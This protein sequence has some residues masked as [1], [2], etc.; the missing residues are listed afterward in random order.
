[1]GSSAV[2]LF[3]TQTP[4]ASVTI[5]GLRLVAVALPESFPLPAASFLALRAF[6]IGAAAVSVG[7]T[8]AAGPPLRLQD[9]VIVTPS[10]RA[11]AI[12]QDFACRNSPSPNFTV[13]PGSLHVLSFASPSVSAVNV[14]L[15]CSGA[16]PPPQPCT[17]H[18]VNTAADLAAALAPPSSGPVSVPDPRAGRSTF[19]EV[20][21]YVLLNRSVALRDAWEVLRAAPDA[22]TTGLSEG[23]KYTNPLIIAGAT[24]G[25]AGWASTD[26]GPATAASGAAPAAAG[27]GAYLCAAQSAGG[28]CYQPPPTTLDLG[29]TSWLMPLTTDS[30]VQ[31]RNLTVLN[32][33]L[34]PASQ[35]PFGLLT[36]PL[37]TFGFK[38]QLVGQRNSRWVLVGRGLALVL[39][40]EE[41]ALWHAD[42]LGVGR[43]PE[44][45]AGCGLCAV[46]NGLMMVEPASY[47]DDG[48]QDLSTGAALGMPLAGGGLYLPKLRS[49]YYGLFVFE[50]ALLMPQRLPPATS[51]E[52][53]ACEA[54]MLRQQQG[55]IGG[56]G[57]AAASVRSWSWPRPRPS[58]LSPL[59]QL[60]G[61][62]ATQP[63]RVENV[64]QTWGVLSPL[65]LTEG[66]GTGNAYVPDPYGG[67]LTVVF[68]GDSKLRVAL[69][70]QRSVFSAFA[71]YQAQTAGADIWLGDPLRPRLLNLMLVPAVSNLWGAN[72]SLTLRQLVLGGLAP[73]GLH[74]SSAAALSAGSAL[75]AAQAAGAGTQA[76]EVTGAPSEGSSAAAPSQPSGRRLQLSR[77]GKAA[78]HCVETWELSHS[79]R[80]RRLG[81]Y[82]N[83]YGNYTFLGPAPGVDPTGGLPAALTNFTSCLWALDMNRAPPSREPPPAAAEEATPGDP[84]NTTG[85]GDAFAL[86]PRAFLDSVVLLVPPGELAVLAAAW[87]ER[88]GTGGGEADSR[89]GYEVVASPGAAADPAL[90]SAA[91]REL[92]AAISASRLAAGA[93]AA[94]LQRLTTRLLGMAGPG[95]AAEGA[96]APAALAFESFEW[97]G[98]AGRNVTLAAELLASWQ[99]ADMPLWRD[100]LWHPD[101]LELPLAVA[102]RQQQRQQPAP[103]PSSAG[104]PAAPARPKAPPL[105][106]VRSPLAP[107]QQGQQQQQQQ[108]QQQE[109][110]VQQEAPTAYKAA[111][112]PSMATAAALA[113]SLA[114]SVCVAVCLGSVWL[115]WRR[116]RRRQGATA[117]VGGVARHD[118]D[119]SD[120]PISK[121]HRAA[122]P[123][124]GSCVER[125]EAAVPGSGAAPGWPRLACMLADILAGGSSGGHSGSGGGS[126]A[127]QGSDVHPVCGRDGQVSR[128][129]VSLELGPLGGP[130][131]S[132]AAAA[133]RKGRASSGTGGTGSEPGGSAFASSGSR[134]PTLANAAAPW[135]LGPD[136]HRGSRPPGSSTLA[137]TLSALYR[138]MAD[139]AHQVAAATTAGEAPAPAPAQPGRCRGSG[140]GGTRGT[141]DGADGYASGADGSGCTEGC[142]GRADAAQP[143]SGHSERP[144]NGGSAVLGLLGGPCVAGRFTTHDGATMQAGSSSS[145]AAGRG[146]A[147][148]SG[149][150]A[151]A[152]AGGSARPPPGEMVLLGELGRGAQGVVLLARWRGLE[153]AVKS[154]TFQADGDPWA[155]HHIWEAALAVT[156]SH[157]NVVATYA[158]QLF[159]VQPADLQPSLAG[160]PRNRH[161]PPHPGSTTAHTEDRATEL[162]GPSPASL[163]A[164]VWRLTLVQE[165]CGAGSLRQCLDSGLLAACRVAGAPPAAVAAAGAAGAAP[166]V[167]AA[168]GVESRPAVLA[169]QSA[170]ASPYRA[171]HM[172]EGSRADNAAAEPGG[173]AAEATARGPGTEQGGSPGAGGAFEEHGSARRVRRCARAEAGTFWSERLPTPQADV[174]TEAEAGV[175]AALDTAQVPAPL[176]CLLVAVQVA[177]G[178]AYLHSRGVLHCDLSSSNV[179][180]R[181]EAAPCSQQ[182]PPQQLQLQRRQLEEQRQRQCLRFLDTDSQPTGGMAEATLSALLAA[183]EQPT[184]TASGSE[185]GIGSLPA[186]GAGGRVSSVPLGGEWRPSG[187]GGGRPGYGYVA[188]VCDFGLSGRLEGGATHLSGDCRRS[189]L[190]SAPE[191]VQYGR[192]SKA[193]DVYA[194]AVLLYEIACGVSLPTLLRHHVRGA[195]LRRWLAAQEAPGVPAAALPATLLA[196]PP[197][198]PRVLPAL[199]AACLQADAWARPD[200]S[201]ICAVLDA[202]LAALLPVA[203]AYGVGAA[204]SG[205]W[206]V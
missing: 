5:R 190:Y 72:A 86:W 38:R 172:C 166:A 75:G 96:A 125:G 150:A 3:S 97:C 186:V 148:A 141:S 158:H 138:E 62:L 143:C 140:G 90:A 122:S 39:P 22:R 197:G 152:V 59:C 23:L 156:L 73:A 1:M 106:N 32:P 66:V 15:C 70:P 199:A 131:G 165:L 30:H 142:S 118:S 114:T 56:G 48:D 9:V 116:R 195:R 2:A 40:A 181:S 19:S 26:P 201:D 109:Q 178:M 160:E 20:P 135:G 191:L 52:T 133:N 6:S 155:H 154:T 187:S 162:P 63:E 184:G 8:A 103:L 7:S 193:T 206:A 183:P 134:E 194:F 84:G 54:P 43:V 87:A 119:G 189:L 17:A 58:P 161:P 28:A 98:L 124:G 123:A 169:R 170:P 113:A 185:L 101:G 69:E 144:D 68:T 159:E 89:P 47:I 177:R 71:C 167:A 16:P 204:G 104:G 61:P 120:Q 95:D 42:L 175:E 57:G 163:E 126:V 81:Q 130:G 50:D 153:V 85:G 4:N 146:T 107:Q 117:L 77:A 196:W 180:L 198:A 27:T 171:A 151:V 46:A 78:T 34:A 60:R 93:T 14:T 11:L 192:T 168:E 173:R 76:A 112:Q 92:E 127:G 108:Q 88:L 64:A 136:P 65:D 110:Q 99:V 174:E 132:C 179:L 149:L 129:A 49:R 121:G 182:P 79:R 147:S 74:P 157:P 21:I 102:Q 12:H 31:L 200:F 128:G 37:W 176:V 111:R 145:G 82:M 35:Y 203:G 115:L 67:G 18:V 91:R 44:E 164:R 205:F 51:K 36:L 83:R 25:W 33:P 188:K 45:L 137:A 24:P 100:R 53:G 10:C 13:A 41:L 139:M 105:S 94:S 202:E 29:G 80:G 55:D